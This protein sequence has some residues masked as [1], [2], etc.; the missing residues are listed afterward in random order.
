MRPS[1]DWNDI[2]AS[3]YFV[4]KFYL[5]SGAQAVNVVAFQPESRR[6]EFSHRRSISHLASLNVVR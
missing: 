3:C 4:L 1:N 5:T 6:F 2:L